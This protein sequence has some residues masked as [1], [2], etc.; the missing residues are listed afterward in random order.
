MS[1]LSLTA[2]SIVLPTQYYTDI[3]K[4]AVLKILGSYRLTIPEYLLHEK[5]TS[6]YI[7]ELTTL[8]IVDYLGNNQIE[9]KSLLQSLVSISHRKTNFDE[10][11]FRLL[12]HFNIEPEYNLVFDEQDSVV[13]WEAF[14]DDLICELDDTFYSVF[15][16]IEPNKRYELAVSKHHFVF[17]EK[18]GH[19]DDTLRRY[20]ELVRIINLNDRTRSLWQDILMEKQREETRN[21]P[22]ISRQYIPSR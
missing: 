8:Y 22:S 13:F 10:Y 20:N 18:E 16:K 11:T 9:L 1:I 6:E 4:R 12:T 5:R 7:E 15:P 21:N 2:K 19:R 3:M 17:S 14:R